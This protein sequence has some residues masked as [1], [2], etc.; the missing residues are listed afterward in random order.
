MSLIRAGSF[1]LRGGRC[2]A[3]WHRLLRRSA[4][5]SG[6]LCRGDGGRE[7][8]TAAGGRSCC[9]SSWSV[10]F[11]QPS[12]LHAIDPNKQRLI[13]GRAYKRCPLRH[14]ELSLVSYALSRL[15]QVELSTVIAPHIEVGCK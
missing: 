9:L 14:P 5:E 15:V 6:L 11:Q 4:S 8:V 3:L 7:G 2:C 1:D 12:I 13:A 10:L